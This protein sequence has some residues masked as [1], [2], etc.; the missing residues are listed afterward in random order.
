[1]FEATEKDFAYEDF[2]IKL[3]DL[4]KISWYDLNMDLGRYYKYPKCCIKHFARY[5]EMGIGVVNLYMDTMYGTDSIE[6]GYVRCLNC[7]NKKN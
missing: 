1:M 3:V 6:V 7:R 4:G 2:I 5:Q